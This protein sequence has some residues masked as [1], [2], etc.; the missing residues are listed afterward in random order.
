VLP[1]ELEVGDEAVDQDEIEVARAEDLVGDVD[2]AA[3]R[4]SRLGPFR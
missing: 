3:T 4:I 2:V 1:A